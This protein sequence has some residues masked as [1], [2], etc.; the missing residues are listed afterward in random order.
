M[1]REVNGQ[2]QFTYGGMA[3]LF[4]KGP[5]WKERR[6]ESTDSIEL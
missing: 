2:T 1:R 4:G 6:I 5:L 3:C